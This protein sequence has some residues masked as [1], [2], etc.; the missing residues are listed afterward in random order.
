MPR[1][2]CSEGTALAFSGEGCSCRDG[3]AR[4]SRHWD[5]E[6]IAS[7]RLDFGHDGHRYATTS[8]VSLLYFTLFVV[9][10]D[11]VSTYNAAVS[12][13][14]QFFD[15]WIVNFRNFGAAGKEASTF[16]LDFLARADTATFADYT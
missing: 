1:P 12:A 5:G 11:N 13:V 7:R 3:C 14:N 2:G 16:D 4:S 8:A 10:S 9:D 6:C 15:V